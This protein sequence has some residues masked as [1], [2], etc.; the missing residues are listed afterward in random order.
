MHN[1]ISFWSEQGI[2]RITELPSCLQGPAQQIQ[3]DPEAYV[4]ALTGLTLIGPCPRYR[5]IVGPR[6]KYY[7]GN[8]GR[9]VKDREEAFGGPYGLL[10]ALVA[11]GRNE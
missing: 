7:D 11:L 3:A 8:T 9:T 6:A 10:F 2:A 1:F 5:H 4:A